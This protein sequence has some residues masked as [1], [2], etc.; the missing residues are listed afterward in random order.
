MT[1]DSTRRSLEERLD[2]AARPAARHVFTQLLAT[3]PA[4]RRL[5]PMPARGRHFAVGRSMAGSFP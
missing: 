5:R 1:D 2:R 3:A 4:W